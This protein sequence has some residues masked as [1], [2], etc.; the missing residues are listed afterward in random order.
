M[1]SPVQLR[2]PPGLKP[3][4]QS[5][6]VFQ[7]RPFQPGATAGLA[8]LTSSDSD[9]FA[10]VELSSAES[11][12]FDLQAEFAAR[13]GPMML[14]RPLDHRCFVFEPSRSAP[15]ERRDY[16]EDLENESTLVRLRS[17]ELIRLREWREYVGPTDMI[18]CS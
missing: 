5:C 3:R 18:H 1:A 16:Q 12:G 10:Q 4:R 13:L 15:R 14:E 7:L 2:L 17:Q 11:F 9:S 8:A 6:W